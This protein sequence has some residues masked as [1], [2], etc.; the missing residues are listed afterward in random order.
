MK[1][2]SIITPC[3]NAEK[4]IGETIE[5]VL[6]QSALLAGRAELDYVICDGLSTD[7]T[8][9]IAESSTTGFRHGLVRIVSQRD[10]G[11]YDALGHGLRMASGNIC[12]YLNAGDYYSKQA[13]D[14]VLDL[15]ESNKAK[16]LTGF[17]TI[18]NERSHLVECYLPFKYRARLFACGG[19]GRMLSFVQ[20]ES[21]FW[22]AE[23]NSSIN[24]EQLST[25]RYAGDFY[26]W[27]QFSQSAELKIVA[28]YIGGFKRHHGQLSEDIDVY[29]H[30][31]DAITGNHKVGVT[32]RIVAW[33]DALMWEL[34]PF[35]KK[36]FN[37]NGLY[38]YDHERQEWV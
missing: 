28:A 18:Y 31:M 35:V 7:E 6:T 20:Q 19:Y 2:I 33:F 21:T 34:P 14:I 3:R 38:R 17:S 5:S 9:K 1:K 27:H 29:Y 30:E 13:F 26:L 15:F 10:S 23:L 11:M 8:V 4:T 22:S 24:F 25:Y 16:W 37:P 32:D 12:A 36:Y